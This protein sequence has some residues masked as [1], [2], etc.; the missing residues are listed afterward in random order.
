VILL[1][2]PIVGAILIYT[3]AYMMV[4]EAELILSC[5]LNARRRATVGLGLVAGT[6]VFMVP[7]LTAQVPLA[8][9]PILGSGLVVGVFC[10]MLLNF[11]FHIS[12][13]QQGECALAGARPQTLRFRDDRG[14]AWRRR[15]TVIGRPGLAVG[16]VLEDLRSAGVMDRPARLVARFEKYTL[17]LLIDYPGRAVQFAAMPTMD[18]QALLDLDRDEEAFEAAMATLSGAAIRHLADR[19]DT[20]EQSKLGNFC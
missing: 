9:K 1:P 16:E 19:V 18:A 13:S 3:A 11:L 15:R 2:A 7:E 12:V 10:A 4:S 17:S 8:F 6:A 5:L 14:A 20:L